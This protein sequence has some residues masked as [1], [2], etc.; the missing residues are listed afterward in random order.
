MTGIVIISC[1]AYSLRPILVICKVNEQ[2]CQH[3]P[4]DLCL[5]SIYQLDD[6]GTGLAA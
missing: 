5:I 2:D 1:E 6:Q 4:E 3:N